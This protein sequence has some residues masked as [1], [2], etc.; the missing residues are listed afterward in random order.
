MI[1]H[2][3]LNKDTFIK[4]HRSLPE[5][6]NL[7]PTILQPHSFFSTPPSGRAFYARTDLSHIIS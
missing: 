6:N 2:V 3:S 4:T 5:Q 1:L 7:G